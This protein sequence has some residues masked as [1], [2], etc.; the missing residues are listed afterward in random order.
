MYTCL[1]FPPP[2]AVKKMR[3]HVLAADLG[4]EA[5]VRVLPLHAG[6]DGDHLLDHLGA[7]QR[8]EQ[9]RAGAGE[10]HAV[11]ACRDLRSSSMRPRNSSTFSAW[12]VLWRW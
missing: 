6:G 8:A 10:E 4:H 3:L 2:L 11:A 5:H 12:R 1:V 7:D 9:A